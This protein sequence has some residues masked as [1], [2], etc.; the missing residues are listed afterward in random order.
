MYHFLTSIILRSFISFD[1]N[2]L[3]MQSDN[4]DSIA[5]EKTNN[6]AIRQLEECEEKKWIDMVTSCY[7][8]K[9]TP[10]KVFS[11]HL[12]RTPAK[13]RILL[14]VINNGK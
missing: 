4:D 5:S 2:I 11:D 9:G 13:E 8:A 7:S 1:R 6:L 12:E 3:N 14:A 10:R